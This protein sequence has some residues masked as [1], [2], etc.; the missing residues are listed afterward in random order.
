MSGTPKNTDLADLIEANIDHDI[1]MDEEELSDDDILP[2]LRDDD[3]P[4]TDPD[5][6]F[7]GSDDGSD[8][9]D[10]PAEAAIKAA[11]AAEN[12][13]EWSGDA[14][15]ASSSLRVAPCSPYCSALDPQPPWWPPTPPPP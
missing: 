11:E 10:D 2:G 3:A 4:S 15:G 9:G 8:S 1:F 13:G 7:D 6:L 14:A 12:A 5:D